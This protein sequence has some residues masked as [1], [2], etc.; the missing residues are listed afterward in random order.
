[1]RNKWNIVSGHSWKLIVTSRNWAPLKCFSLLGVCYFCKQESETIEENYQD[2]VRCS[3][4]QIVPNLFNNLIHSQIILVCKP[5][6][7][8]YL[9]GVGVS[10]GNVKMTQI[11]TFT[12]HYS[13]RKTRVFWIYHL[14]PYTHASETPMEYLLIMIII[15]E[16][17]KDSQSSTV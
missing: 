15:L 8:K 1:M 13:Q 2:K 6:H 7:S 10:F 11:S 16:G 9:R 17:Y 12:L 14:I 3:S 5:L 4:F